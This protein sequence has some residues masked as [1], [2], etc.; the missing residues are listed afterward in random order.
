MQVLNMPNQQNECASDGVV[1]TRANTIAIIGGGPVGFELAG[2]ICESFPGQ[3][4]HLFHSRPALAHALPNPLTPSTQAATL[5]SLE[6]AWVIPNLGV[7]VD[8]RSEKR[9][10][11]TECVSTCRFRWKQ[12]L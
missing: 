1:I 3:E 10:V 7:R 2:E 9:R 4:V 6:A 8:L 11:S 12:Y 5:S